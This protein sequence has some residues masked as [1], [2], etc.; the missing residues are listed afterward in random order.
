MKKIRSN[1]NADNGLL[2]CY[3][4]STSKQGK[5]AL[6]HSAVHRTSQHDLAEIK[7]AVDFSEHFPFGNKNYQHFFLQFNAKTVHIP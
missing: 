4:F 5:P 6:F 3:F 1:L 2:V 7:G